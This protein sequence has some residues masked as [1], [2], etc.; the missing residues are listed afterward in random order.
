MSDNI[1]HEQV[2]QDINQ[3]LSKY[4]YPLTV[5]QDVSK[6]LVDSDCLHYANQQLRYLQNIAASGMVKKEVSLYE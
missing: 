5:L 6:R 2:S 4:D 3:L 1:T